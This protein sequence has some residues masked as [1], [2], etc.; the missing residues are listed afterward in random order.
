CCLTAIAALLTVLVIG[1]W[2]EAPVRPGV[3]QAA[4]AA[5]ATS[6]LG[7]AVAQ[8]QAMIRATSETNRKLD[9]II[10]LLQSGR[11]KV[12]LEGSEVKHGSAKTAKS[13][14]Q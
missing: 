9:K 12:V 1:L 8:R 11:V 3:S 14:R 2:A 10:D 7:N 5:D 4:P 13:S 6:G